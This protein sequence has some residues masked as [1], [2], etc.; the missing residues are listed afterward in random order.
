[1]QD[2]HT[3]IIGGGQAGLATSYHLQQRGL[4]HVVL[5][6]ADSPAHVWR[7]QR[8]DSFALNTPN[9]ATQI[10][11]AEYAGDDPDGFLSRDEIVRFFEDYVQRF[12][13][14]MRYGICATSVEPLDDGGWRV[15]TDREEYQA[16]NVVVAT[17]LFQ[18]P[19][20]PAFAKNISPRLTQVHSSEYRN[21]A[22]LPEGA[23]L[24]VGSAQSGCQIAD[25]LHAAG[26]RVFI[27]VG[28]AGRVP[29]RYR[30]KDTLTWL[31]PTGFFD[32]T[33]EKLPSLKMRFAGN[34]QV[35]SGKNVLPINLHIF[36]REG[37]QL[38]GR[39]VGGD[40]ERVFL[41]PD[42]HENLARTDAFEAEK[43][44]MIDD[45]IAANGIEAP[46]EPHEELKDGFAVDQVTELD[47]A[48]AGINTVLWAQGYEF[49]FSMVR[50][51]VT[52]EDG[53]P[54]QQKGVTE[55]P[56]LY[57]MGLPWLSKFQSGLLLGVG[58]DAR[59]VAGHIAQRSSIT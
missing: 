43:L 28:S 29:R 56:G 33:A 19:K 57:F 50:V 31:K 37:I 13:L 39:F 21:A 35:G 30:G 12:Q 25:D 44:K 23:V 4:E 17:G 14:P 26:R 58:E 52:D 22:S 7:D 6:Q 55:Y 18:R 3:V 10:P 27:S 5:E 41:A 53:F 45:Y 49:D 9:W 15:V 16:R 59:Y 48:A 46:L 8:W 34:P 11:G 2:I 51:P 36:A 38:L 47:L 24:V 42:L 54:I 20:I 1:M 32:R 40:G